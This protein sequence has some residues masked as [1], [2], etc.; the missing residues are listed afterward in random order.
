MAVRQRRKRSKRGSC[1]R[2]VQLRSGQCGCFTSSDDNRS[3]LARGIELIDGK[4]ILPALFCKHAH[5]RGTAADV[6]NAQPHV[7]NDNVSTSRNSPRETLSERVQAFRV[8]R[9]GGNPETYS[10]D[11]LPFRQSLAKPRISALSI[12][13]LLWIP[14]VCDWPF[15]IQ[16]KITWLARTRRCSS[17]IQLSTLLE[18]CGCRLWPLPESDSVP[19]QLH[20]LRMQCRITTSNDTPTIL[21]CAA[22]PSSDHST[23][24]F[25][26]RDQRL[27]VV[28]LKTRLDNH[29]DETRASMQYA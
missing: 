6:V 4:Q 17:R 18:F 14:R 10:M 8:Y 3:R 13:P 2:P 26:N 11:T 1:C 19:Q 15:C 5:S 16:T 9:E 20:Q 28:G 25:D 23:G 12:L 24:T 27:Y 29:V 22:I 7:A 21:S